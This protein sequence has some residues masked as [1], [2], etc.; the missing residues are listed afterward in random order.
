MYIIYPEM[1]SILAFT[2]FSISILFLIRNIS[3]HN[4]RQ[5]SLFELNMYRD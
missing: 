3:H 5:V 4:F 2:I 1:Y